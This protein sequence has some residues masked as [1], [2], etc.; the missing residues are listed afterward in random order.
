MSYTHAGTHTQA[1]TART[2][3]SMSLCETLIPLSWERPTREREY[4]GMSHLDC[5]SLLLVSFLPFRAFK[6]MSERLCPLRN[7]PLLSNPPVP[8]VIWDSG[9]LSCPTSV[10]ILFKEF[11]GEKKTAETSILAQRSV[12]MCVC[13]C[14]KTVRKACAKI[15][16]EAG[17]SS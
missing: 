13:M 9:G 5:I 12:D 14:R 4:Y 7:T 16:L 1:P 15:P 8:M 11:H 17:R 10:W 2:G 3:E 6:P